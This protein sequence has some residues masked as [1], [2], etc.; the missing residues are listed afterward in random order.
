MKCPMSSSKF[1]VFRPD[2]VKKDRRQVLIETRGYPFPKIFSMHRLTKLLHQSNI[3]LFILIS[4][5]KY[6]FDISWF[7]RLKEIYNKLFK[8]HSFFFNLTKK[9]F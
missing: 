5:Q 1:D 2:W 9:M 8:I 4:I 3:F 7:L 6:I